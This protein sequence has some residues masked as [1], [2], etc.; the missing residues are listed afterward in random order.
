MPVLPDN[1]THEGLFTASL[2][3]EVKTPLAA[4]RAASTN[5]RKNLEA[6]TLAILARETP[7][8]VGMRDL[9]SMIA[10]ALSAP[11]AESAVTGLIPQGRIDAAAERLK[12]AGLA[13]NL[14]EAAAAIV[15]GGWEA[16]IDRLAPVLAKAG[17]PPVIEVLDAASKLRSNLR[18]IDASVAR[19]AGIVSALHAAPSGAPTTPGRFDLKSCVHDTLATLRHAVPPHV[20]IEVRCEEELHLPGDA[21]R[22][23]QVLTNLIGNAFAALPES[24]GEVTLEAERSGEAAAVRVIDNGA[25]IPEPV[26]RSLFSPFFT[27]KA[28]DK[29]SGLG[30][31]IAREIVEGL[32][33]SLTF[34]SRPGRTCFEVRLPSAGARGGAA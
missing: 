2:V 9:V 6:L 16:Q 10:A 12:K 4:L 26:Q 18:S 29:G 19:L 32:G 8:S 5:L 15:R 21:A 14:S 11:G 22:F 34:T 17:I 27:T 7:E 23:G 30:L 20:R 13:G 33:G 3:H 1:E 25:G 24:G 28:G 31:F